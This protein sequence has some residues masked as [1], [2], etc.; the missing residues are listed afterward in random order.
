MERRPSEQ[1]EENEIR[2][3]SDTEIKRNTDEKW[4]MNDEI[5]SSCVS[6]YDRNCDNDITKTND[7]DKDDDKNCNDNGD[8][9]TNKNKVTDLIEMFQNLSLSNYGEGQAVWTPGTDRENAVEVEGF[10]EESSILQRRGQRRTERNDLEQRRSVQD[11]KK[12]RN[13]E[14]NGQ[15]HGRGKEKQNENDRGSS[16]DHYSVR[17]RLSNTDQGDTRF[18]N[19]FMD[20]Q[21]KKEQINNE[22]EA[23]IRERNKEIVKVL[24]RLK[25]VTKVFA[26]PEWALMKVREINQRL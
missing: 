21:E 15:R 12:E 5:N 8:T 18:I 17:V 11:S 4:P 19:R 20:K 23:V 22:E 2:I 26:P 13:H 7:N 25:E 3:K 16:R 10:G 1:S 6:E 14:Q 9:T 24:R